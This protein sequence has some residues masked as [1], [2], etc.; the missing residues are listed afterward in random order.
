MRGKMHRILASLVFGVLPLLAANMATGQTTQATRSDEKGGVTVKAVYVTA[1]Y[2]KASPKDP[3]VGKVDPE[4]NVVFAITLDT[5][6]G[7]LNGYDFLKNAILRNDRGQQL[8]PVRWVATADGSHHRSGALLF[9][10]ADQSGRAIE[11]QAKALE[12][13]VRGLGGIPQRTLRW[14]LPLE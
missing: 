10:K 6:S 12:L 14:T 4:R 13:L 1:A 9:P 8:A 11:A 5:H 2:F 3:L 7:D